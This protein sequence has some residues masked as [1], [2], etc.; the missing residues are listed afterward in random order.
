MKGRR[1]AAE[2]RHNSAML[3]AFQIEG[4]ARSKDMPSRL[5]KLLIEAPTAPVVQPPHDML[6]AM[7]SWAAATK[8]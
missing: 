6:L 2:E 1:E 8:H 3:L 4:F 7:R 5:K